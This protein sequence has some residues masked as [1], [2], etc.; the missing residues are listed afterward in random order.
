MPWLPVQQELWDT[1]LHEMLVDH[2]VGM[3]SEAPG[4]FG[5]LVMGVPCLFVIFLEFVG[6][7]QVTL[8]KESSKFVFLL[9][10]I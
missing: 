8:I 5:S 3:S 10:F 9:L 4:G 2:C 6:F 1:H 7:L